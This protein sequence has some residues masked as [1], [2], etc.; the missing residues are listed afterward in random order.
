[1]Y[2]L[3]GLGIG[4]GE[5]TTY[6]LQIVGTGGTIGL[7]CIGRSETIYEDIAS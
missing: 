5:G 3:P 4:G 6:G 7:S 2:P 1:M